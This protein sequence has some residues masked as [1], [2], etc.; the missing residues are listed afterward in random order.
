[1]GNVQSTADRDAL[2]ALIRSG[3]E[4]PLAAAAAAPVPT[5]PLPADVQ[6]RVRY[7][8]H[9]TDTDYVFETVQDTI[10]CLPVI[11]GQRRTG[12]VPYRALDNWSVTVVPRRQPSRIAAVLIPDI[13]TDQKVNVDTD[14]GDHAAAH[15]DDPIIAEMGRPA[16]DP[17]P[18]EITQ[19]GP[20][21]QATARVRNSVE[22]ADEHMCPTGEQQQ[23]VRMYAMRVYGQKSRRRHR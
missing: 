14:R 19:Y 8:G 21:L 22:S 20:L 4:V 1:M 16:H 12:Q 17:E 10:R 18:T 2:V 15:I 11:A 7:T 3:I 5:D 13:A 9:R 23:P 6:I